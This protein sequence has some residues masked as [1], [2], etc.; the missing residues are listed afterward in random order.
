MIE[1]F[2]MTDDE[3]ERPAVPRG[4]P[5]LQRP[6]R[7]LKTAEEDNATARHHLISVYSAEHEPRED[8]EAN[9][10]SATISRA[11]RT[12]GAASREKATLKR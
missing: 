12:R 6:L 10:L 1:R 7:T 11:D 5:Y 9:P 3:S 2:L 8:S 4:S